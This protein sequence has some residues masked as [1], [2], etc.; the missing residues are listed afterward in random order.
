MNKQLRAEN[1]RA[2]IR[3][4]VVK[5]VTLAVLVFGTVMLIAYAG[6]NEPGA[7]VSLWQKVWTFIVCM[8][9]LAVVSLGLLCAVYAVT[10]R[11]IYRRDLKAGREAADRFA[12]AAE[13]QELIR[14]SNSR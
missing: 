9:V 6:T 3:Y 14:N 4:E 8:G 7:P 1:N 10:V 13:K 12:R 11:H 2:Y 5:M